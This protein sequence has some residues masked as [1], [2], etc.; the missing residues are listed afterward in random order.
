LFNRFHLAK[1]P[2]GK[3]VS[4]GDRFEE[5]SEPDADG[6]CGIDSLEC[7]RWS[8]EVDSSGESSVS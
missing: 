2:G 1:E 4:W 7:E 8:D 5:L 3:S 6:R